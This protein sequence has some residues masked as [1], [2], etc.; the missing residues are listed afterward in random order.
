M[1]L[2]SPITFPVVVNGKLLSATVEREIAHPI[3]YIF[4]VRFSDG[5]VDEFCV[6]EDTTN[7]YGDLPESKAYQEAIKDDIIVII[8]INFEKFYHVFRDKVNGVETN[9]W[10]A[11][12]E[13]KSGDICYNIYYN[14]FFRFQ[15]KEEKENEVSHSV[16]EGGSILTSGQPDDKEL[17]IGDA[18]SEPEE[19]V[20]S[21]IAEGEENNIDPKIVQQVKHLLYALAVHPVM[22]LNNKE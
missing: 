7:I 12:E 18:I 8:S 5:H 10:V 14:S 3:Q 11:E 19:W 17:A 20:V 16:A 13:D 4:R 21:K 9:I 15:M 1:N 22:F 2:R 6:D